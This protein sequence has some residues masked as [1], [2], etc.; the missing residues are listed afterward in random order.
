MKRLV[1]A[2]MLFGALGLG[3]MPSYLMAPDSAQ[4]SS[5]VPRSARPAPPVTSELVTPANAH[6]V[7][8]MLEEELIVAE[9]QGVQPPLPHDPR[10][11]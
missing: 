1:F 4:K 2:A 6:E 8:R 11:H 7:S 5:E 10:T 3:C 9:T